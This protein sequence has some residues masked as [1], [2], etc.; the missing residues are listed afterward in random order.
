MCTD[1]VEVY[2]VLIEVT[3]M[4]AAEHRNRIVFERRPVWY[5]PGRP[6]LQD[7]RWPCSTAKL[8]QPYQFQD[9][10][11][12]IY[13]DTDVLFL[14][15]PENLWQEFSKFDSVQVMALAAEAPADPWDPP[16]HDQAG[17]GGAKET[18]HAPCVASVLICHSASKLF[19]FP[20]T[21]DATHLRICFF[22]QQRLVKTKLS[23]IM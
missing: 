11:A 15:P 1:A 18:S 9:L 21:L 22:L 17:G 19:S 6:D 7:V 3:S 2:R 10:D 23:N 13:I 12:V 20:C 5:P 14:V 8:F 16:R 4:W